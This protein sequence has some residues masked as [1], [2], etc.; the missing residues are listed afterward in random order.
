MMQIRVKRIKV[1]T[2]I[3]T[4]GIRLSPTRT[5]MMRPRWELARLE[6][7]QK[8]NESQFQRKSQQAR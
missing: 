1:G 2:P 8:K 6:E 5:V 3:A 7:N 4:V